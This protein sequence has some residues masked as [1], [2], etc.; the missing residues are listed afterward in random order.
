MVQYSE[1]RRGYGQGKWAK[2][3]IHGVGCLTEKFHDV[4][5]GYGS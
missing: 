4:E 2:M 5:I 3:V 1:S